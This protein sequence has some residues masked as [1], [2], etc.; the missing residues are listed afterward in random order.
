MLGVPL[1]VEKAREV[2]ASVGLAWR[3]P[4]KHNRRNLRGRTRTTARLQSS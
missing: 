2:V 1:K 4:G 3:Q